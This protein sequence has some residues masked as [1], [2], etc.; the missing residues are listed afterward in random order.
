MDLFICLLFV[1]DN[2]LTADVT[3]LYVFFLIVLTDD[4]DD[5]EGDDEEVKNKTLP[6]WR[7]WLDVE[8][9]REANHWLPWRPDKS[10]GQS[11]EDCDDPE[12][13]VLV[14]HS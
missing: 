14:M 11:E 2:I 3:F 6:K 12:R 10:K 13:Q 4:D 1:V 9:S 7:I 8:T 5:D